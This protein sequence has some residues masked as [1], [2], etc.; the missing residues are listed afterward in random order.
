MRNFARLLMRCEQ[1]AIK[2]LKKNFFS[3]FHLSR[4]RRFVE[5]FFFIFLI[6]EKKA[7]T[8]NTEDFALLIFTMTL[9]R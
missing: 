1:G 8:I 9:R 7:F 5:R 3:F 4:P 2:S 6:G